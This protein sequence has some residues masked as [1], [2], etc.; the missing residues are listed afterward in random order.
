MIWL[1]G[2]KGMLGSELEKQLTQNTVEVIGT[3]RDVDITNLQA[4]EDFAKGKNISWIINCA[5]YTA[6]D[7][8]E[9]EPELAK[10]LN[11]TGPE[12]IA[13][14]A[15][16]IGAKLV[17]I[18]TD[19]VFDGK[20][21]KPYPVDTE[22][23]PQSVYG[24]TKAE[25]EKA[26]EA[27]LPDAHYIIRT[28][29]LYGCNGP[30]FVYTMIK[31]MNA[32]ESL[33]VVNDQKGCPTNA[34][35]LASAII[36]LVKKEN[37]VPLSV[38]AGLYHYCS[39]GQITWYEFALAIQKKAAEKGLITNSCTVHPCTSAEFKSKAVRPQ[40]S[41]MDLSKTKEILG[42]VIPSWEESLNEFLSH[43]DLLRLS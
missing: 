32:K 28:A 41:V 15:K 33:N 20:G 29:W 11:V 7:K 8:A 38:P 27:V 16:K 1:I 37:S 17:H 40:Y 14:T 21:T 6:V 10:L 18:S 5:A 4:L 34:Q 13:R 25:G 31:L 9:D 24:R 26:I 39:E 43:K 2:N 12:N 35:D 23:N 22:R 3:D 42:I 19:Y 30:N 36:T